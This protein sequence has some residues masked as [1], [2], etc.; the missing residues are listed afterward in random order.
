MF[1]RRY[2]KEARKLGNQRKSDD[3]RK[4]HF[5]SLSTEKTTTY[6]S[7]RRLLR[8]KISSSNLESSP[9]SGPVPSPDS[10]IALTARPFLQGNALLAPHVMTWNKASSQASTFHTF[11]YHPAKQS[12]YQPPPNTWEM[13]RLKVVG[14]QNA[15]TAGKSVAPSSAALP[16]EASEDVLID[17]PESE[18]FRQLARD[19]DL[20]AQVEGVD[21]ESSASAVSTPRKP[22]FLNIQSPS[23]IKPHR[24]SGL[25]S[26]PNPSS[27]GLTREPSAKLFSPTTRGRSDTSYSSFADN[28][29]SYCSRAD[30]DG[31]S[32]TSVLAQGE[33]R[34]GS[35]WR[36]PTPQTT[37]FTHNPG[38]LPSPSPCP[39][40]H[41]DH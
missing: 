17:R 26:P 35:I 16:S 21:N 15:S 2:R 5:L 13:N 3:G 40:R 32:I 20:K 12:P 18:L 41:R 34:R 4:D 14:S 36:S 1:C 23:P 19:A 24:R 11:A 9:T 27:Q 10:A 22:E 8:P 7:S 39:L 25:S 28:D 37:H 31:L 38:Q 6:G 30:T 33:S 29:Q